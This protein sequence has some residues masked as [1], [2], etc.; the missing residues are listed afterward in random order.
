LIGDGVIL[1]VAGLD[2]FIPPFIKLVKSEFNEDDHR[3]W[4]TG[5]VKKYPI[6]LDKNITLCGSSLKD[7]AVGYSQLIKKLHSSEKIILH[8]LFNIRVVV[9][10]AC[11]PWLHKKCYWVLWGGDLYVRRNATRTLFWKIKEIF[12]TILIARLHAI[13]TTVP[14]DFELVRKW[15]STRAKYIPSLM[16]DSHV[17]RSLELKSSSDKKLIN[18]QVGNSADPEN[19]HAEVFDKLEQLSGEVKFNVY[20][21]LSYGNEDY[22]QKVIEKGASLFREGFLPLTDFMSFDEY[23]RYMATIDVA[24]FNHRRQQAMGNIIGLLSMGKTVY[25]RP[26]ET[27]YQFFKELGITVFSSDAIGE[28]LKVLS[29][30]Q[31]QKNIELVRREFSRDSLV[32]SWRL[33]FNE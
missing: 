23:N 19:R 20:C 4:L 3:Y 9:L 17:A 27:P 28:G 31:K 21:P 11:M 33:I 7:K 18:I 30:K 1:H 24:I 29:E 22:A 6:E 26:T 13:T 2:K 15:Y 10:L 8:G 12:R 32:E 16:Y 14:G 25:L 5:S